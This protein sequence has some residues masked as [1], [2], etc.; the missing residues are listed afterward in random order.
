MQIK[1]KLDTTLYP[2]EWLYLKRYPI[3]D[4]SENEEKSGPSCFVGSNVKRYNTLENNLV[5]WQTDSE[6]IPIQPSNF[7]PRHIPKRSENICPQK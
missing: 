3:T 6:E 7:K 4:V 2:L 1:V 5:I